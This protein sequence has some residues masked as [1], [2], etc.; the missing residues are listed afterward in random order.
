MIT[1]H[2]Q[3][4]GDKAMLSRAEFEQLIE[5]ARHSEEIKLQISNDDVP[6]LGI[7]RLAEQ[8]GS[9]DFWKQEGQDIYSL[10]DG[11]PI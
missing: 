9:F 6:T 1:I 3:F 10:E 7:M 11:E 8:A 4:I 5:L 2:A